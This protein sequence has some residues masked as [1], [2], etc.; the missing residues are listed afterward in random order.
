M[1]DKKSKIVEFWKS[2]K[3]EKSKM[4]KSYVALKKDAESFLVD[5]YNDVNELK[6]KLEKCRENSQEKANFSEIA[7]L[8]LSE[9]VAAKKLKKYIQIFVDEFGSEP[10]LL[11]SIDEDDDMFNYDDDDEETDKQ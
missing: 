5:K 11:N 1:A 4:K 2:L 3:S 8:T 6:E 7:D 10:K 9:E